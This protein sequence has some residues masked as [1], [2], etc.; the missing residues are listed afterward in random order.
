MHADGTEDAIA[1]ELVR[2][3]V[4]KHDI[5]IAL[6][7]LVRSWKHRFAMANSDL[8]LVNQVHEFVHQV[9]NL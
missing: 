9:Y 4:P 6:L 1:D 8:Q 3:G 2:E 7:P 5:L